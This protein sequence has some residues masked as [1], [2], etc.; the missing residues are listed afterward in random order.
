MARVQQE[1]PPWKGTAV[2]DRDFVDI[3]LDQYKG[4]HQ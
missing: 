3:S 1:A 2:I 4:I